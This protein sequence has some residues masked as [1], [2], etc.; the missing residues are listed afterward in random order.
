MKF[1]KFDLV[2]SGDFKKDGSVFRSKNPLIICKRDG[3]TVRVGKNITIEADVTGIDKVYYCIEENRI[4]ISDRFRDFVDRPV[5]QELLPF[6]YEKGYVP[7]PFTILKDVR[8]SPPG[9]KTVIDGSGLHILSKNG[10]SS[11]FSA[12]R[13]INVK[14]FRKRFEKMLANDSEDM[15]I[16]SYSGGFDSAV[17]TCFYRKKYSR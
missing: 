12:R 14:D 15:L 9:L 16:S 6:Q 11:M 8:K 17:L 7:F 4:R 5:D 10:G 3:S 2:I 1:G 13:V